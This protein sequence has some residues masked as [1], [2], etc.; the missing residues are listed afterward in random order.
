MGNKE[1]VPG[2]GLTLNNITE[3]AHKANEMQADLVN[4]FADAD[5]LVSNK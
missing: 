5:K 3:A 2:T 1:V 4:H